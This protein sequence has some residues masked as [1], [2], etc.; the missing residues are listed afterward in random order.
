MG[1]ITVIKPGFYTTVHDEGRFGFAHLRVPVA[2][3][4]DRTSFQL[5]NHLLR[6][7]LEAACLEMTMQGAVLEFNEDTQI[8]LCGAEGAISCNG[9]RM[10]LNTV[11]P[12]HAGDVVEIGNFMDG[13][14]M[15]MAIRGGITSEITLNSRSYY[16]GITSHYRVKKGDQI[17][18]GHAPFM[19]QPDNAHVKLRK[20]TKK[21]SSLEAYPG[22]EITQLRTETMDRLF[23]M[24]F[25]ISTVQDRM[26]IQL[27]ELIPNHQ[28]E[29]LTSPVYPGT[30]QLTPSGKLII[31]M[32]DAQVTG[33]YPRILQLQEE[34]I[35]LLAQKKP[36]QWIRF[37]LLEGG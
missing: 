22:P 25:S 18:Y 2:G 3:A 5:A 7:P 1:K 28:K 27:N 26:G 34:A 33:G 37:K 31:L 36:G 13:Q 14:R 23:Q 16:K 6:N 17:P 20:W 11:L 9:T 8:I 12:I 21:Y 29:I 32:R 4:M 30:V 10:R 35:S 24:D 19:G 15:Y